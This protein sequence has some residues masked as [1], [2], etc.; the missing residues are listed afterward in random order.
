MLR[1]YQIDEEG[2]R[3]CRPAFGLEQPLFWPDHP[4]GVALTMSVDMTDADLFRK[5]IS[6][7][8]EAH[9]TIGSLIVKAA[10]DILERFPIMSGKWLSKDKIWVPNS[11]EICILYAIQ[12]GDSIEVSWIEKASQKSLLEIS[13]ELN[14]QIKEAK[15]KSKHSKEE[16]K[17][18][19]PLFY[20]ANIG[21]IG[22]VESGSSNWLP[23]NIT[24]ELAVCAMLEKSAVK[25]NQIQIRKMMNVIF[26]FDHRAMQ[27]NIPIEFLTQLKRNLEE[28]ATYLI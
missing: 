19:E 16:R 24:G 7:K 11:G 8:Y 21:T 26:L 22:P 13:K 14:A 1:G 4:V 17:P 15:S 25:D 20:L 6:E 10:A 23:P 3:Y 18:P 28:P 9:I 5:E 12:I 27:A 2:R